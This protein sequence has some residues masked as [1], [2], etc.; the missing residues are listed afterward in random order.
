MLN[1]YCPIFYA[2]AANATPEP[3]LHYEDPIFHAIKKEKVE[4]STYLLN[5]FFVSKRRVLDVSMRNTEG[6]TYLHCAARACKGNVD[7]L[8]II[9]ILIGQKAQLGVQ[10]NFGETPL[11]LIFRHVQNPVEFLEDMVL[12][13][14][15]EVIFFLG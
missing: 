5:H 11:D 6:D 3:D 8:N 1:I 13:P 2:V 14:N 9:N 15:I 4:I 7:E 12:D 10:N